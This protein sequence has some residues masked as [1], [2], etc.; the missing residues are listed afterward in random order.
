VPS[1]AEFAKVIGADFAKWS[2]QIT[3]ANVRADD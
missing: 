2:A 1:A 3:R